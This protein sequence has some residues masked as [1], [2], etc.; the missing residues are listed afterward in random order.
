MSSTDQ[1][2][3]S[4]CEINNLIPEK[5]PEVSRY[6]LQFL[7]EYLK[8]RERMHAVSF[9][10]YIIRNAGYETFEA[11]EQHMFYNGKPAK[12]GKGQ[13]TRSSRLHTDDSL[14][15][16]PVTAHYTEGGPLV[17][18]FLVDAQLANYKSHPTAQEVH[19]GKYD[20]NAF[21]VPPTRVMSVEI[22]N[23]DLIIFDPSQLHAFEVNTGAERV[24]EII[25][26]Q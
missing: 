4:Q 26:R 9:G 15:G 7:F 23:T 10:A 13:I 8:I 25:Y 18:V 3:P 12:R 6:S 20:V 17:G 19:R 2:S 21:A 24:S 11:C 16:F 22:R 14:T 1:A 5:V